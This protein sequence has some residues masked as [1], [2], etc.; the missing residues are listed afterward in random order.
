MQNIFPLD[1]G[2]TAGTLGG[3]FTCILCS[4]HLE[5]LVHTSFL[6]CVGATV[7]F[8]VSLLLKHLFNKLN[9]RNR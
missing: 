8:V 5:D 1:T 9:Q 3:T 4:Q 6:A 2:T 7:S